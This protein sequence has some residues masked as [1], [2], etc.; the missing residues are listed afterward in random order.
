MFG[1]RFIARHLRLFQRGQATPHLPAATLPTATIK[2][3]LTSRTTPGSPVQGLSTLLH[4]VT[5]G[6]L[7]ASIGIGALALAPTPASAA[8][9]SSLASGGGFLAAFK[10]MGLPAYLLLS[11]GINWVGW[12]IAAA[13]KTEKFYDLVGSLTFTTLTVG[14]L[15]LSDSITPRKILVSAM[16]GLWT[17]RLGSYLVARIHKQGKD[18]RFDE[19]KHQPG[20]FFVYWT[21]QAL[22]VWITLSPVLVIN[23]AAATL[24][25]AWYD[26]LGVALW[27]G[28]L[29]LEATADRQKDVWRGKPENK[30]KFIDEGLWSIS[31]HPNYFGEI[32]T[33]WGVFATCASS[34]STLPQAASI[35]SPL[36]VSYLLNYVSGVPILEKQADRRWGHLAEYQQYK[37]RTPVLVPWNLLSKPKQNGNHG[38]QPVSGGG[39]QQRNE[40]ESRQ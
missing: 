12:G 38:Y 15:A 36:F 34:F 11:L 26:I 27:G 1:I 24:P 9:L 25:L 35:A 2:E 18:S 7:P 29:A 33:W 14:S 31:R 16:V 19:V 10:S 3:T 13:L 40:G 39:E 37:A 32:L 22:W 8:S 5:R 28:G 30:G 17:L 4:R 6:A 23:T 21:M 20:M